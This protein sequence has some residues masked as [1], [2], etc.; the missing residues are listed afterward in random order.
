[1]GGDVRVRNLFE[2]LFLDDPKGVRFLLDSADVSSAVSRS[3]FHTA[4][5]VKGSRSRGKGLGSPLELRA[6]LYLL[7]KAM[8]GL[9]MGDEAVTLHRHRA[10][11]I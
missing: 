10:T 3:L 4:V 9:T 1:M 6:T 2:G 5:R 11:R 7:G 8:H